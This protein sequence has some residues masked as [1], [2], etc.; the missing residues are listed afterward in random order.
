[1][2]GE[3]DGGAPNH[4]IVGVGN[5]LVYIIEDRVAVDIKNLGRLEL[6]PAA[7]IQLAHALLKGAR[8]IREE[9][10]KTGTL[11]L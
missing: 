6:P 2:P 9:R 10:P 4:E 11:I 5:A 7:A 8:M 3:T 1:M